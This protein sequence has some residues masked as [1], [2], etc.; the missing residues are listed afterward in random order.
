MIA[1]LWLPACFAADVPRWP[2]PSGTYEFQWKDAEFQNSSGFPVKVEINGSRIRVINERPH[3]SVPVGELESATL[4]WHAKSGRWVLGVS[5]D[6]NLAPTVGGCGDSD[7]HV[8]DF[9]NREIWT[10]EWG[11]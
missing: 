6:D 11:P 4:M 9:K 3:G 1:L 5:K 10:C 7:P 8:I 2:L